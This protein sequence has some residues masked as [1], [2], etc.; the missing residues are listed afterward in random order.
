MDIDQ[1]LAE[2]RDKAVNDVER[3]YLKELLSKKKGKI[4]ETA[5]AAG[6]GVRQIHK[7]MTKYN[8]NRD[9]FKGDLNEDTTR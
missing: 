9:E 7:L 8:L 6:V 3:Q 4:N 5:E 2:V 1:T